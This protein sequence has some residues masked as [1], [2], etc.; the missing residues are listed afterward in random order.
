M[1]FALFREGLIFAWQTLASN[2]LR[3]FLSLLGITIGIFAII[4]VFTIVDALE[5]NVRGT[6]ESLGNNVVYIQKW[7]WSFEGDYPWWKYINRPT[8]Q[9]SELAELQRRC[10]TAEAIAYR[11]GARR[12]VKYKSVAIQ[13]AIV[14]GIS[15]DFYR[16]K[17][18]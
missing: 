7:P 11:M 4:L 5:S 17:S 10:R 9:Y 14:G 15:H 8:A 1:K 3:S 13:N 12:T 2:K 18:F 16:I 6:F